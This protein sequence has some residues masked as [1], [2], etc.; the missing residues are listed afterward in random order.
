MFVHQAVSSRG[1]EL[2]AYHHNEAAAGKDVCDTHFVHQQ[3]RVDVNISEGNGGRKVST[4]KQLAVGLSTKSVK[5]TTNQTNMM[6]SSGP[7][8]LQLFRKS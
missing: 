6:L 1:M 5:D 4:A 8:M 2:L 3:A 7:L